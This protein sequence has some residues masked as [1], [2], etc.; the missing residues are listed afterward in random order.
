M[1]WKPTLQ[2]T[3]GTSINA[4]WYVVVMIWTSRNFD[5]MWRER[6][7]GRIIIALCT[8]CSRANNGKRSCSD[9]TNTRTDDQV[10]II[11]FQNLYY[12]LVLVPL[13][14]H[15]IILYLFQAN[16]YLMKA[17]L[18][19]HRLSTLALGHKQRYGI[20]GVP[21]DLEATFGKVFAPYEK[22]KHFCLKAS[23]IWYSF[24]QIYIIW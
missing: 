5:G 3:Y 23:I 2:G 13:H 12:R 17:A 16:A 20:D 9:N 1:E 10:C 11:L 18:E 8:S 22:F 6:E 4:F 19:K 21:Q 15:W 7:R 24:C 14:N